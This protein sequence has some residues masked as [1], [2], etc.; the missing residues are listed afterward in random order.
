M[1]SV[2]PAYAAD[3][4]DG[5]KGSGAEDTLWYKGV[6]ATGNKIFVAVAEMRSAI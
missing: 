1:R 4:A 5:V 2:P 3:R 6:L